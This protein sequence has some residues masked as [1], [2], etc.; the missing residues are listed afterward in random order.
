LSRLVAG[1]LG[2]V[3]DNPTACGW[4]KVREQI[5]HRGLA[6]TVRP[7]QSVNM[8]ALD[9]QIHVIDSHKPFKLFGQALGDENGVIGARR[10]RGGFRS[11]DWHSL[12]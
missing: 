6:R 11:H 1:D 9:L 4:Q 2:A 5:K 12:R 3:I 7:N 10:R 8:A